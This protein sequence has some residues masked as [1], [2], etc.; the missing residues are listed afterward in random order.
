MRQSFIS[1][2][3]RDF[4]FFIP[5]CFYKTIHFCSTK[6]IDSLSLKRRNSFQ[7]KNNSKAIHRFAPN[8]LSF[9]LQQKLWKF[10]DICISWSS[11]KTALETKYFQVSCQYHLWFR[12]YEN[13]FLWGL[14]R[15]LEIGNTTVWVWPNIWRLGQVENT[16][17]G[18]HVPNKILLNAATGGKSTR[19]TPHPG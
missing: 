6:S 8:P 4:P 18:M 16:K 5:Y 15:N 1:L 19:S 12:S 7:N 3:L 13:F 10:N 17:F 14:T 2:R 11:Q 9:K